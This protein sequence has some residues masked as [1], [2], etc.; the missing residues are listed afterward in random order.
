MRIL[1]VEDDRQNAAYLAAQLDA[2][3]MPSPARTMGPDGLL[4]AVELGYDV[5]VLDRMLP[6]LD[7]LGVVT[8]LRSAG[9]QTPVLFLTCLSGDYD[10]V[11]GLAAGG[12]DYLIKPFA[13]AELLARLTALARRPPLDEQKAILAFADLEMD[14]I[15]GTSSRGREPIELRPRRVPPSSV[16]VAQRRPSGDPKYA[17]RKRWDFH[18]DPKTNIVETHVSRLRTKVD[19]GRAVALIHTL[20]GIGYL[21]RVAH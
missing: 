2:L 21:L 14:L 6:E 10:Q 19:R 7:G 8:R 1:I 16:P 4:R 5:I 3:V 17:A 13:F 15:R 12:D 11:E 9:I 18:F 20:R